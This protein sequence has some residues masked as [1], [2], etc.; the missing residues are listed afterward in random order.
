[1]STCVPRS[2]ILA[3][4]VVLKAAA[5]KASVTL[6]PAMPHESNTG[7]LPGALQGLNLKISYDVPS[8]QVLSP[9]QYS[10]KR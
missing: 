4:T 6:P 7:A 8:S 2:P 9:V 1:M 10:F 5:L 3:K